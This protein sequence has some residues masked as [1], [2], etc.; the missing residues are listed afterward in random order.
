[1]TQR[2]THSAELKARV[3]VEALKGQ[4]TCNE[5]ASDYGVHPMLV[6]QW[7]KQAI[8]GMQVVFTRPRSKGDSE[9]ETLVA[10]LYQEVGQL[11]VELDWLKKKSG[12][13]A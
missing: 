7:K 4:R 8:E 3:A 10:R 1:M 2:R 5:I 13:L 11:K 9:K 6:T 12:R